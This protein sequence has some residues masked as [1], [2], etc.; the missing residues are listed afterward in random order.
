MRYASV[1][2]VLGLMAG[3]NP[4]QEST[5]VKIDFYGYEPGTG[6][7]L[8]SGLNGDTVADLLEAQF[9]DQNDPLTLTVGINHSRTTDL[10]LVARQ[11]KIPALPLGVRYRLHL[12]GFEAADGTN[13]PHL[14]GSSVEFD[15]QSGDE[16]NVSVQ[17]AA[18]NC[19]TLNQ[20][21]RVTGRAGGTDDLTHTR[22]GATATVLPDGRVVVIGG[23]SL[24]ADGMPQVVHNTIEVYEP[25]S[26]QFFVLETPLDGP[27]AWHSAT[28]LGGGDI[29]VVGGISAGSEGDWTTANSALI[30]NVDG[31]TEA[32]R[33]VPP[34]PGGEGRYEHQALRL[35]LDGSVL[36]TGGKGADG[37]P[38]ASTWRYFPGDPAFGTAGEFVRQGD[39]SSARA[40]HTVSPLARSL[41]LAAVAGGLSATGPLDTIEVFSIRPEQTGCAGGIISPSSR[42]GCFIRTTGVKLAEARWGHRAVQVQD[43]AVTTFVGGYASGD[44]EQLARGIERLD[45]DL[46][47]TAA[48]VSGMLR[49]GRGEPSATVLHDDSILLLGGRRG[50][51]PVS[52]GTRLVPRF[53]DGAFDG[54]AVDELREHCDLSEPR[55][56]HQAV[57]QPK[58]GLVL[59]VGGA[60][61]RPGEL[62]ASRRAELYFPRIDNVK[63]L[64]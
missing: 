61:G 28:H 30:V 9:V 50:Q 40:F 29:L 34:L 24:Q 33:V 44:M 17:V 41:E 10:N 27:R 45:S 25:R 22:A 32:I 57:Y 13:Q 4:E 2:V 20:S 5:A 23:A 58:R 3:C 15:V 12:R 47:M 7:G 51:A 39:L 59:V 26:H 54:Y 62:A 11:G 63:D 60:L 38:L 37:A 55:F 8:P 49:Y 53:V 16:L 14:Y 18:A 46:A 36:I 35:A 1:L 64:Y 56:G 42:I 19:V 31:A 48:D 52:V 21:S 43:G 6:P